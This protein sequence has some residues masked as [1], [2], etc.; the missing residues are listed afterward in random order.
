M[1]PGSV[2]AQ[3]TCLT[4]LMAT[5]ADVLG[6][7]LADDEGEDSVSNLPLWQGQDAP[8][9][10]ATVHSSGGGMFGIRKGNWKLEMC[11]DA[12]RPGPAHAEPGQP[13]IQ[14]NDMEADPSETTNVW[15]RHPDVVAELTELLT[16]YVFSG[17]STPGAPQKNT[18]PERWPQINWLN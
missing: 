10:E 12:G 17:R 13:P 14:L 18:G 16:Q 3:T 1:A 5:F 9:R 2:C 6:V 4:D 15:D 7:K 8:I 11:P